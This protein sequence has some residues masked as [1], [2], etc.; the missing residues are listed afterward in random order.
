MD[1][2]KAIKGNILDNLHH[3]VF[4]NTVN[5]SQKYLGVKV[6]TGVA[7]QS[8]RHVSVCVQ[9]WPVGHASNAPKMQGILGKF[10]GVAMQR[11][12]HAAG[13]EQ[14]I[15]G[16]QVEPVG[17]APPIVHGASG[18]E[19]GTEI[20][21]PP[22]DPPPAGGQLIVG[23]HVEPI[24]QPVEAPTVH[25]TTGGGVKTDRQSPWQVIVCVHCEPVGQGDPPTM[26]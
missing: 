9:I 13:V 3:N 1:Y 24:E 26:H 8:P 18:V 6:G 4:H 5:S 2:P 25:G 19:V 20:H 7:R 17:Q 11:P 15:V 23:V 10:V 22:Q 16:V 14:A 21:A 12:P